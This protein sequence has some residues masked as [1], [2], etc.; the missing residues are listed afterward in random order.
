MA[1]HPDVNNASMHPSFV[2]F[3]RIKTHGFHMLNDKTILS[4]IIILIRIIISC[5]LTNWYC[6]F[7]GWSLLSPAGNP[8]EHPNDCIATKHTRNSIATLWACFGTVKQQVTY[9]SHNFT[10]PHKNKLFCCSVCFRCVTMCALCTAWAQ[11]LNSGSLKAYW[12]Q[13]A[14]RSCSRFINGL[15]LSLSLSFSVSDSDS[16]DG[17]QLKKEH[18]LRVFTYIS[19]WTQRSFYLTFIYSLHSFFS[20]SCF[21]PC[22]F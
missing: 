4:R 12:P 14:S 18:A 16:S 9:S 21:P 2:P 3:R 15:S 11:C 20:H 1:V 6:R 13:T 10:L 7:R 22:I 17:L 19:T 8:P 5:T